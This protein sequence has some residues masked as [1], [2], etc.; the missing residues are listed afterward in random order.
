MA[1]F[2]GSTSAKPAAAP[3]LS[4]LD[5]TRT[6]SNEQAVSLRYVCGIQRMALTWL[7][8]AYNVRTKEVKSKTG[9]KGGGSSTTGHDYYADCAGLACHGPVDAITEIW[10]NDERLWSG[11]VTR[12][13][14]SAEIDIPKKGHVTVYWGT[15][16]QTAQSVLAAHGHPPYRGQC[17]LFFHQLYFGRDTVN[18]PN[19]EVVLAR[20]PVA[21][22]MTV[23]P[24]WDSDANPAHVMAELLTNTRY[25][26]GWNAAATLDLSAWNAA[27]Q[28]LRDEEVAISPLIDR[29]QTART[30]LVQLC[31]YFDGYL[32]AG[33][34]G[35]LALKLARPHGSPDDLPLLGEY[36]LLDT[37][38]PASQSWRQTINQINLRFTDRDN[39]FQADSEPW[40]DLANLRVV[41]GEALSLDLDR[42]WFTR[43][44]Q[45]QKAAAWAGRLRSVPWVNA[46]ISIRKEEAADIEPGAFVRLTYAQDKNWRVSSKSL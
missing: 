4:G 25:G 41:G 20:Q 2:F 18:A 12:S 44:Y 13:G 17:Y 27:A 5:S 43:R 9:G 14:D 33:A 32:I 34:G 1:S 19:I 22:G 39:K 16:T 10:M 11:N 29:P 37:P 40:R 24:S 35:K 8:D 30:L 7:S 21:P 28:Q 23:D 3:K 38:D 42:P 36:D 26:L 45:A 31:E 15:E 46:T 6:S